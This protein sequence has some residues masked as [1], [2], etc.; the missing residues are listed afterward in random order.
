MTFTLQEDHTWSNKQRESA[1]RVG[2]HDKGRNPLFK[3]DSTENMVSNGYWQIGKSPV[4][5]K[6]QKT[7]KYL[8]QPI[9]KTTNKKKPTKQSLIHDPKCSNEN[10]GLN[11]LSDTLSLKIPENRVKWKIHTQIM[12][13]SS[14]LIWVHVRFHLLKCRWGRLP[15]SDGMGN[16]LLW[17]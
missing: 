15:Q 9:Q 5:N 7:E 17:Q 6:K 1:L 13:V 2:L 14:T 16:L 11:H 4:K 3:T 12:K 8:K 10:S